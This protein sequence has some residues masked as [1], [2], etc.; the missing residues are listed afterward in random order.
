MALALGTRASYWPLAASF[1]V[2]AATVPA[3]RAVL[4]GA[5]VGLAAWSIPFVAIVHPRA[6]VALGRTHL[7]GHFTNWGGSIATQPDV[8]L[9][10]WCF[11]RGLF[12]DGLFAHAAALAAAAILAIAFARVRLAPRAWRLALVVVVPYAA[13]VLVGQNVV[14]QP[15]HLL[16]LATLGCVALGAGL[17]RRPAA[18]IA[19]VGVALAASLPLAW[20][21]AHTLPA[22]AQAA[23][24]TAAAFPQASDVAVFGGRS[25]RFFD[26]LAPGIVTRPRTWLSEVDVEL[27]RLDRLPH[28]ILITSE[29]ELD[30]ERAARVSDGPTFCREARL[31]RMQPCLTLRTYRIGR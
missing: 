1:A 10:L 16:P 9:R 17:A 19:T 14:E 4:A 20:A 13:W 30:A 12:Y 26:E 31:D 18:A 7:L 8:P 6:L 29:V 3:R 2:V 22:A 28:H 23:R 5:V 11:S 21:R 15:R 25:L 24:W 27:E